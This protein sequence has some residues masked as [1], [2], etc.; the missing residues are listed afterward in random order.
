MIRQLY[1]PTRI[2][3]QIV[4]LHN[5]KTRLLVHATVLGLDPAT[6]TAIVLEV[7]NAIYAL[8]LYRGGIGN[9]P[10]AAY[11]RIKDA[12]YNPALTG[13]IEW[14]TFAAPTPMPTAVAYGCLSRVFAYVNETIKKA[15][16]YDHAIGLD[17]GTEAPTVPAPVPGEAMPVFELRKTAGGKLEVVWTKGIYDGV[18]LEFDLGAAG[19]QNDIDLRPNYTLNWL[20]ATGTSAIIKVRLLFIYKGEDFG[21]WSPWQSWTLTGV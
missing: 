21:S 5:F 9:F 6:V 12:L 13:T 11:Q 2:G 15:T 1:F 19:M 7:D 10:D 4:W 20:P 14:L 18:K 17:L 16:A 8:D 3:D